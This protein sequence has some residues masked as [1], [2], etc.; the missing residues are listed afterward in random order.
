TLAWK[1]AVLARQRRLRDQ[2][3]LLRDSP[4]PEVARLFAD[5]ENTNAH[6]A[7]LALATPGPSRR[8]TW[9]SQIAALTRRKESLEVALDLRSATFRAERTRSEPDPARLQ[10]ALP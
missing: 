10:A 5:L 6:L 3:R 4:D 8:E 7:S 1:G 9:A 2:R